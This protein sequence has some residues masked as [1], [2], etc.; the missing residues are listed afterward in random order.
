[1]Y[2]AIDI[3]GTNIRVGGSPSVENPVIGDLRKFDIRNDYVQDLDMI[4]QQVKSLAGRSVDGIGCCFAGPLNEAKD[5]ILASPNLSSW[6]GKPFVDDLKKAFHCSVMLENDA[7]CAALGE[8]T[9]G[10]GAGKSFLFLIWGTGFGGAAV[11][12]TDD[13]TKIQAMEPG[14]IILGWDSDRECGCGQLGCAEA[15]LGGANILKYLGKPANELTEVEWETLDEY[16]AHAIINILAVR[17]EPLI[18]FGGGIAINQRERL[19]R[20]AKLVEQRIRIFPPPAIHVTDLGDDTGLLGCFA[21]LNMRDV[22]AK[23]PNRRGSG[24]K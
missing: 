19:P 21:L 20:I 17:F 22:G 11:K 14:H 4:I 9:Y 10:Y 24:T 15:Y 1:M 2:I 8:A 13:I 6:I 5:S 18:I 16:M 12:R 23:N 3:G 7:A